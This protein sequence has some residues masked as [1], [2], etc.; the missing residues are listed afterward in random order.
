M[1]QLR[2][3]FSVVRLELRKKGRK[4]KDKVAAVII[5]QG[6]REE[7]ISAQRVKVQ[8]WQRRKCNFFQAKGAE[9]MRDT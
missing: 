6:E 2:L 9:Y 3:L 4:R 8:Q 5:L 7:K 1:S